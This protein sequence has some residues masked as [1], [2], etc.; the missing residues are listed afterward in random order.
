MYE[1]IY[2]NNI[3]NNGDF[4]YYNK[5]GTI[6]GKLTYKDTY[7]W[8]GDYYKFFGDFTRNFDERPHFL[9]ILGQ[10]KN[11]KKNGEWIKYYSGFNNF[12]N[13]NFD[14][15]SIVSKGHYSEDKRI[16][17][18]ICSFFI[19]N[20]KLKWYKGLMPSKVMTNSRQLRTIYKWTKQKIPYNSVD[21]HRYWYGDGDSPSM[22]TIV[23]TEGK[24]KDGKQEGEWIAYR[25][26][27]KKILE[28]A[29]YEN[30]E[31]NGKIISYFDNGLIRFEGFY[32]ND[33]RNGLWV[34]YYDDGN[35]KAKGN[36][37]D[38]EPEGTWDIYNRDGTKQKQ[39]EKNRFFAHY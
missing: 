7:P 4:I 26:S 27:N 8:E 21:G 10:Y 20:A 31:L 23:I 17:H 39:E 36:I 5:D 6:K 9:Q 13:N 18:W 14:T 28:R 29:N 38:G 30:N 34:Y 11:G 37:K 16:D 2:E 35:I 33:K 32:N 15:L 3:L 19:N 25:L 24:F 22:R 12:N 1:G